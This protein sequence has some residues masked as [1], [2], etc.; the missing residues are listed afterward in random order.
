VT[1]NRT[2]AVL[3][4]GAVGGSLIV[5][6]SLSG[7]PVVCVARPE[8]VGI[9]ALSGISVE[10]PDGAATVRPEVTDELVRPVGLLL[11]T[12]KAPALEEALQRVDPASVAEGVVVP[13]LNGLEHMEVV[14]ARFPGRVAAGT[15]S[16]F[17]AYRVGRVQIIEA[18]RSSVITMA[19]EE[20]PRGELDYAADVLRLGRMDVR[21]GESERRVL[22]HKAARISALAAATAASH[23]SVGELRADGDWNQRLQR[24]IAEACAV[25]EADGVPLRPAAQW[26]IIEQMADETTTS[27][28]RDVAAG[29][30]SELDAI[31]GSVLRVAERHGIPTPTLSALASSAGLR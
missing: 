14:R 3:G 7:V 30:R 24:A 1:S 29:R 13:L 17:Q 8:T 25:A 20:V 11:V 12:V 5:R 19:S 28:A 23:R 22:W 6:L 26:D 4:P 18:T 15:I 21:V 9:I 2:V 10:S 16:H 31:V 27:A